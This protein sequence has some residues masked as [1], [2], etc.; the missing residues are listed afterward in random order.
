MAERPDLFA[1]MAKRMDWLGQ[2]QR[3]LAR[4][5]SNADTPGF[6]PHDLTERSFQRLLTGHVAPVTPVATQAS[7]MPGT[8][9]RDGPARSQAQSEPY[10]TTPTGNAVVL[11]E[12]LIKVSKTQGSYQLMTNLY[13]KHMEMFRMAVRGGG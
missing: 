8:V 13:R 7:H 6:R 5:V 4:N 12:Q 10:E 3:V 9:V 2:R 1:V 11:E